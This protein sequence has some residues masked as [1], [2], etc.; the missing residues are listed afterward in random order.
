MLI[1]LLPSLLWGAMMFYKLAKLVNMRKE[2][3]EPTALERREASI[4][5]SVLQCAE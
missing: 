1:G 2:L 5:I 4:L 3:G